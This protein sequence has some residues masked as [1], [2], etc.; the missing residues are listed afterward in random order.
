MGADRLHQRWCAIGGAMGAD[1][2]HQRWCARGGAM[3]ADRLH[4]RWCARG[5]AMG[6]DRLHHR[7]CARGGA[8]G[9]DRLRTT[10]R[11]DFGPGVAQEWPRTAA[12]HKPQP[13]KNI[14]KTVVFLICTKRQFLVQSSMCPGVPGL[15]Q[16]R[17]QELPRSGPG[18]KM[19][20]G[21][22]SSPGI[23]PWA[24]TAFLSKGLLE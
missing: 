18:V 20:P 2:L 13:G 15:L 3:G 4:Q 17:L 5:G 9:A 23:R 7:W 6:A 11:A 14:L 1:R 24:M 19:G 8:M 22:N 10:V 16:E 21:V 12:G